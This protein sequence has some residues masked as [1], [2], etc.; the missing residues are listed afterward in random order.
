MRVWVDV[1]DGAN[2]RIGDGP[3][4]V[5]SASIKRK[6][7]GV[8]SVAIN[9]PAADARAIRLLQVG[10]RLAIH[11]EL[12]GT[13]R[14]LGRGTIQSITIKEST[15]G[16]TLAAKG[17]DALDELKAR[18]THLNRDYDNQAVSTVV[19]ALVGLANW[20]ATVDTGLGSVTRKFDGESVLKALQLLAD[21]GGWHLRHESGTVLAFGA[22]GADTGLRLVQRSQ[23]AHDLYT[24]DLVTLIEDISLEQTSGDVANWIIPLGKDDAGGRLTLEHST[25]TTPY[26][27]QTMTGPDSSTLYFLADSASIA[28]YG[29]RERVLALNTIVA[30]GSTAT[31]LE[32]AANAL[33]D[34]AAATLARSSERQDVYRVR[35]RKAWQTAV[36]PGDKVRLVYRGEV[37]QAG[38]SVRYL[39]TDALYWVLDVDESVGVEG[40]S[41]SV[42]ISNVDRQVRD[43]VQVVADAIEG[44]QLQSVRG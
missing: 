40:H 28:T 29:Q 6:L 39:D 37:K 18:T 14:E 13:L 3:V 16:A 8:G 41:V 11:A 9:A 20:T 24:N 27:I 7:D 35:F 43:G 1:L 5:Q 23:A 32:R 15:G 38:I 12:G 19:A 34:A 25:R 30:L 17:P 22:L 26:T 4:L 33:Y 2:A 10:R 21:G 42:A 36:R 31:D 44:V